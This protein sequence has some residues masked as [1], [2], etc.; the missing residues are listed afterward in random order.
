M[1]PQWQGKNR[2]LQFIILNSMASI[3]IIKEE[4]SQV[5]YHGGG[6]DEDGLVPESRVFMQVP[7]N[8]L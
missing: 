5:F 4:D 7:A 2:R 3:F 8:F 6:D 1:L